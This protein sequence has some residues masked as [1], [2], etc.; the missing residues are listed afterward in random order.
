MSQYFL[1]LHEFGIMLWIQPSL[2][3]LVIVSGL[4]MPNQTDVVL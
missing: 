4:I 1:P 3:N 2:L